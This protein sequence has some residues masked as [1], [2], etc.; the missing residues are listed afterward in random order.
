MLEDWG[1]ECVIRINK[2][3]FL[4]C[5]LEYVK[6]GVFSLTIMTWTHA[7]SNCL[8]VEETLHVFMCVCVTCIMCVWL[9]INKIGFWLAWLLSLHNLYWGNTGMFLFCR[10]HIC[11]YAPFYRFC[12]STGICTKVNR[13][14]VVVQRMPAQFLTEAYCFL[15]IISLH[16][17]VLLLV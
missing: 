3:G 7:N 12:D 1:H 6:N 15:M 2:D 13:C 9:F 10:H 4:G 11:S 16:F 14:S 5:G 8:P 17:S